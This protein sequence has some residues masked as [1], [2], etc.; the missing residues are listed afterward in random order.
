LFEASLI[1]LNMEDSFKTRYYGYYNH[2]DQSHNQPFFRVVWITVTHFLV[3]ITFTGLPFASLMSIVTI[4]PYKQ[5]SF[6]MLTPA[7]TL[8]QW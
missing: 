2:N 8:S 4:V 3:Q 1:E 6:D 5:V 7:V